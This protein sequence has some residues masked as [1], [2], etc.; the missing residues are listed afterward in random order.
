[1][2]II[3]EQG[4]EF[5]CLKTVRIQ[6]SNSIVYIKGYVYQSDNEGCITNCDGDKFHEWT[7]GKLFKKH[8]LYLK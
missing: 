3:I 4:D 5:V 1:M 8:F 7:E 2:R 6:R